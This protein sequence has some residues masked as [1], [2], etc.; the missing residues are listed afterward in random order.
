MTS[1]VVAARLAD[2]G[3]AY[4]ESV[5]CKTHYWAG[6]IDPIGAVSIG[7]ECRGVAVSGNTRAEMDAEALEQATM[8]APLLAPCTDPE[9]DMHAPD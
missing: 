4:D 3:F 2:M 7:G 1:K 8:L 5:T 6:T 9:C